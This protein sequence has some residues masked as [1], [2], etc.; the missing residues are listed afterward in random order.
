MGNL[1]TTKF[2]WNYTIFP[3]TFS[4]CDDLHMVSFFVIAVVKP[5]KASL[6]HSHSFNFNVFFIHYDVRALS[7]V[8]TQILTMG[9][10][11]IFFK[12]V[13]VYYIQDF[14]IIFMSSYDLSLDFRFNFH[15]ILIS[16]KFNTNSM[17]T[18]FTY[19]FAIFFLIRFDGVNLP[20]FIVWA[21]SW[22]Q[23][24]LFCQLK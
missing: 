21:F 8:C 17:K 5:H 9:K 13:I 15:K 3:E 11:S 1:I 6:H 19:I 24:K 7:V 20:S 22:I 14:A 10:W 23:S 18:L 16:S 4:Q 12:N 2:Y